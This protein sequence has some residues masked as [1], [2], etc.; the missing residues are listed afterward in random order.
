MITRRIK[1]KIIFIVFTYADYKIQENEKIVKGVKLPPNE[2][3]CYTYSSL[4]RRVKNNIVLKK[5]EVCHI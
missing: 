1:Q 5:G 2:G 3:I 4:G